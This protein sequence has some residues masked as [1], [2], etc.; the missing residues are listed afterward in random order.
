MYRNV[1]ANYIMPHKA[2]LACT[3]MKIRKN[4]VDTDQPNIPA[5]RVEEYNHEAFN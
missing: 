1:Q 2:L 5:I 3:L 4:I